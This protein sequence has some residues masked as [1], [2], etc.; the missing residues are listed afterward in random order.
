MSHVFF[1]GAR[2]GGGLP[3]RRQELGEGL[4]TSD[5][6]VVRAVK[7][8]GYSGL[9]QLRRELIEG[10]RARARNSTIRLGRSLAAAGDDVVHVFD[11]ALAQE[12]DFIEA[13]RA[14]DRTGSIRDAGR[15]AAARLPIEWSAQA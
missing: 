10:L 6:T 9:P 1:V 8:L 15:H 7:A 14:R 13:A 5:A 3:C 12:V 11:R 2:R 4:A